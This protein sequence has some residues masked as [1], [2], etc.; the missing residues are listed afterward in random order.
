MQVQLVEV[1]EQYH[2]ISN[3]VCIQ[4]HN[5]HMSMLTT[6]LSTYLEYRYIAT[7]CIARWILWI[8]HL[9]RRWQVHFLS[10]ERET[11]FPSGLSPVIDNVTLQ[12]GINRC[13]E[14][15][16]SIQSIHTIVNTN[17]GM[18]MK[19]FVG[20]HLWIHLIHILTWMMKK[21]LLETLDIGA[22][23]I[24]NKRPIKGKNYQ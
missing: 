23:S 14:S 15:E 22:K 5:T 19:I 1:L 2:V 8:W 7:S 18:T 21:S 4:Y 11:Q 17:I 24:S 6:V 10:T 13:E 3:R 12:E 20:T 9:H 16:K